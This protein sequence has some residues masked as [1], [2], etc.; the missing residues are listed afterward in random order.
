[1]R[2]GQHLTEGA[3]NQDQHLNE[4]VV[5]ALVEGYHQKGIVAT[6]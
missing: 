2:A 6:E 3:M 4:E 1:M 5:I